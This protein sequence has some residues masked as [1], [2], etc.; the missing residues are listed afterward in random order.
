MTLLWDTN[1]IRQQVVDAYMCKWWLYAVICARIFICMNMCMNKCMDA[2]IYECMVWMTLYNKWNW[3][4][5]TSN[6]GG[7]LM[8]SQYKHS[9]IF[10]VGWC[11]IGDE[12]YHCWGKAR[13]QTTDERK[14]KHQ[15]TEGVKPIYQKPG[16]NR[17]HLNHMQETPLIK[18]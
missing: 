16:R 18:P 1:E 5:R 6:M 2:W 11:Y 7:G 12:S 9:T 3:Q 13:Y 14:L 4:D 8:T 15:N 17:L 10:I